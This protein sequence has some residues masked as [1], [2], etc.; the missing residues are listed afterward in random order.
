[1]RRMVLLILI[2]LLSSP[3]IASDQEIYRYVDE[4]GT[5]HFVDD[6]TLVPEKYRN[7]VQKKKPPEKPSPPPAPVPSKTVTPSSRE[8]PPAEKD[9]LGRGEDWWRAKMKEWNDKLLNA[10]K[11]YDLTYAA[12]RNK[13]KELEN[14]K[15]K[16][17]SL[18]RKLKAEIKELEAKVK[19]WERQR[20]EA[21]NMVE[22]V[23]PRQAE[24]DRANPDWLKPKE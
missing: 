4:K 9:L 16:P 10:Q 15:F 21:K 14:S 12:L 3:W 22:K 20:D 19:D 7:Q 18:K 5:V 23:L 2:V 11:N 1:M 6:L 24:N 8:S 17:D 13:T